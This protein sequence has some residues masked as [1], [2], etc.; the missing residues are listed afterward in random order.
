REVAAGCVV[1]MRCKSARRV[2]TRPAEVRD[3]AATAWRALPVDAKP[4]VVFKQDN[5]S[6]PIITFAI[7]ANRPLRELTEIADKLVRP[8][9]ER[10]SGVGDVE[11]VGGLERAINVWADANRLDAYQLPITTGRNP[12]AS[13]TAG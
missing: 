11:I 8:Q 5:D 3:R 6:S 1:V 7:S 12:L 4:P 10:S 9:L 13:Q 2:A